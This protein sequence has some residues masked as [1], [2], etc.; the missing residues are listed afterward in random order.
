MKKVSKASKEKKKSNNLQVKG[1]LTS[2]VSKRTYKARQENS[3]FKSK[4]QK[5]M[6]QE[7]Y[8]QS[9]CHSSFKYARTL[10]RY[11][12]APYKESSRSFNQ[13]RDWW[14]SGHTTQKHGTLAQNVLSWRITKT[15]GAGRILWPSPE[16]GHKTLKWEIAPLTWRKETSLAPGW[17]RPRATGMYRPC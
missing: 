8:I 1:I 3:I 11:L 4:E 12:W 17:R 16:A 14:G 10:T 15:E 7:F 6:N 5:Y 9:S 13:S 2:D